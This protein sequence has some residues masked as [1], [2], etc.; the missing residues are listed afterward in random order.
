MQKSNK[1]EFPC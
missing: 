1:T